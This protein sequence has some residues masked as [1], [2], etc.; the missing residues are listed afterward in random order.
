M[1]VDRFIRQQTD[2]AHTEGDA[3]VI[4]PGDA[5]R[6][7]SQRAGVVIQEHIEGLH[8]AFGKQLG[9]QLLPDGDP[10]FHPRQHILGALDPVAHHGTRRG[11]AFAHLELT[12]FHLFQPV[13]VAGCRGGMGGIHP[14][15]ELDIHGV[16]AHRADRLVRFDVHLH[17]VPLVGLGYP[18]GQGAEHHFGILIHHQQLVRFANRRQHLFDF[19]FSRRFVAIHRPALFKQQVVRR[20]RF[21][22]VRGQIG[23]LVTQQLFQ[24]NFV[25]RIRHAVFRI[26]NLD[27]G[28]GK[29]DVLV[30]VVDAVHIHPKGAHIAPVHRVVRFVQRRQRN[31]QHI[32]V[33]VQLQRIHRAIGA[34][35]LAVGVR[36]AQ[37]DAPGREH[38]AA[39]LLGGDVHGEEQVNVVQVA[40][41]QIQRV[42]E[43]CPRCTKG[44]FVHRYHGVSQ[45]HGRHGQAEI[46]E[47]QRFARRGQS[48]DGGDDHIIGRIRQH[49]QL[50]RF[51][52]R[53]VIRRQ[54]VIGIQ[55]FL[56]RLSNRL[57]QRRHI[58]IG[59]GGQ[60]KILIHK[61]DFRH[62]HTGVLRQSAALQLPIPSRYLQRYLLG[63]TLAGVGGV[64][65]RPAFAVIR[66][67]YI[68][69]GRIHIA[70]PDVQRGEIH[71]FL[72]I[73]GDPAVRCRRSFPEGVLAAVERQPQ[74]GTVLRSAALDQGAVACRQCHALAGIRRFTGHK[75]RAGRRAVD[76]QPHDAL[77]GGFHIRHR[78]RHHRHSTGFVDDQRASAVHRHGFAGSVF[79]RTGFVEVDLGLFKSL[80][81][82]RLHCFGVRHNSDRVVGTVRFHLLLGSVWQHDIGIGFVF[83]CHSLVDPQREGIG[84]RAAFRPQA[85]IF[86]GLILTRHL[87]R[88]LLREDVADFVVV[89]PIGVVAR[90]GG[91]VRNR[92]AVDGGI[93]CFGLVDGGVDC[94]LVVGVDVRAQRHIF[95]VKEEVAQLAAGG[96]TAVIVARFGADVGFFIGIREGAVL[97]VGYTD[98]IVVG[99]VEIVVAI[100]KIIRRGGTGQMPP[101]VSGQH[102]A[103]FVA[104]HRHGGHTGG[105]PEHKAA[106]LFVR[107][108]RTPLAALHNCRI[109]A[110]IHAVA[111]AHMAHIRRCP[112]IF[113]AGQAVVCP[114]AVQVIQQ[115]LVF[116]RARGIAFDHPL[117]R[118]R[119]VLARP[120]LVKRLVQGAHFQQIAANHPA[121]AIQNVIRHQIQHL[122]RQRKRGAAQEIDPQRQILDQRLAVAVGI[123]QI[124]VGVEAVVHHQRLIAEHI[125][126]SQVGAQALVHHLAEHGGIVFQQRPVQRVLGLPQGVLSGAGGTKPLQLAADHG[127]VVGGQLFFQQIA[128]LIDI[129]SDAEAVFPPVRAPRSL[130]VR[131]VRVGIA[132]AAPMLQALLDGIQHRG[133]VIMRPLRVAIRHTHREHTRQRD[134][135]LPYQAV[136]GMRLVVIIDIRPRTIRTDVSR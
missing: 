54:R 105:G 59:R 34:V 27:V 50:F 78:Q 107:P 83:G 16:V 112:H 44:L 99:V 133:I 106:Q 48:V 119:I 122:L 21:Q 14:N 52:Q 75:H 58:R 82:H 22:R 72:H 23:T 91:I 118:H 43:R 24:C 110:H 131:L 73:V 86:T 101:I 85:R 35:F 104:V 129:L 130:I 97:A 3:A 66:Y 40:F 38:T 39:R 96:G 69:A 46:P 81:P 28:K 6:V 33:L 126:A 128:N 55:I 41:G 113:V 63:A 92:G 125:A 4:R 94:G 11:F 89:N 51:V 120:V 25:R 56:H 76:I 109:A 127:Q 123:H 98:G 31:V 30:I 100:R 80:V 62:F 2:V 20:R 5:V 42:V 108:G 135:G 88:R 47:H 32:L 57:F 10:A 71:R 95:I 103:V 8:A 17:M 45:L 136:G 64:G 49:Q 70:P 132:D 13:A 9:G 84:R 19:A 65:S 121:V 12:V 29:G 15:V 68:I 67:Q 37:I 87:D 18:F 7:G 117:Q 36:R 77:F 114:L 124:A 60:R 111:G 90:F 102:A 53:F 116:C 79:Q 1:R 61:S 26:Q 93:R 74:S 115:Y 134:L